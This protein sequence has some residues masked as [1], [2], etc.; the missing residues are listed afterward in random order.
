MHEHHAVYFQRGPE[1]K[2]AHVKLSHYKH[3]QSAVTGAEYAIVPNDHS[4]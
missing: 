1:R 4:T 2:T 3:K